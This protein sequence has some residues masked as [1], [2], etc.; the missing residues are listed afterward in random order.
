MTHFADSQTES[1]T[2]VL[3]GNKSGILQGIAGWKHAKTGAAVLVTAIA[4][5]IAV[6][7]SLADQLKWTLWVSFGIVAMSLSFI[8]GKAGI[9]SF[10]QNAL[11]GIG[12]YGYAILSL[13]LFPYSGETLRHW[14]SQVSRLRRSQ[15]RSATSCS[16]AASETSTFRCSR[17]R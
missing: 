16:M 2:A 3:T 17:W 4:I 12:A 7:F 5:L 9:F 10:G 14:S 8:W 15:R 6:N 11:F 13:N 1:G